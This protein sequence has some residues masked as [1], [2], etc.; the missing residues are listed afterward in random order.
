MFRDWARITA[1]F[2]AIPKVRAEA[3]LLKA[4]S[5]ADAKAGQPELKATLEV[6]S[7]KPGD[8]IECVGDCSTFESDGKEGCQNSKK[9]PLWFKDEG[10]GA[11]RY[12]VR[13]EGKDYG[14]RSRGVASVPLC[15]NSK[16]RIQTLGTACPRDCA[17]WNFHWRADSS[18]SRAKYLLGP[19]ELNVAL[20]TSPRASTTTR[21]ATLTVP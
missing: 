11:K 10:N 17:G 3:R 1:S 19:S 2:C 18:A 6:A 15:V 14:N 4:R 8:I 21:I 12:Q 13:M 16:R 9:A 7:L 20:E 5:K